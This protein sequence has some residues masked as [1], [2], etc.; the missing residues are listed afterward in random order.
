M[1][2][3]GVTIRRLDPDHATPPPSCGLGNSRNWH[4]AA[5]LR[6]IAGQ[7]PL[8]L[9]FMAPGWVMCSAAVPITR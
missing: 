7:G 5:L 1:P 4:P 2:P 8:G 6:H 3:L 9:R